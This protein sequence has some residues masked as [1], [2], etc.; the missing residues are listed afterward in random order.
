MSR[1]SN[2]AYTL[3]LP[4]VV[5][6]NVIEASAFNATMDDVA[7][8]LTDSLSVTGKG[9]MANP[10]SAPNGAVSLPAFTFTSDPNSG[11][12]SIGADNVGVT[13][14]GVKVLEFQTGKTVSPLPFETTTL[15]L[16]GGS[17][18]DSSGAI[19]FGNENLSTL[20]T[21]A[22]RATTINGEFTVLNDELVMSYSSSGFHQVMI[23]KNNLATEFTMET[24]LSGAMNMVAAAALELQSG[25]IQ[26]LSL[27]ADQSVTVNNGGLC[28]LNLPTSSGV[29]GSLWNDSGTVKV[30][31]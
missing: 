21:L 27:G 15:T 11:F 9:A 10:I 6:G 18:T 12:Y 26:T 8:A 7:V 19:D 4:A 20:G 25:G 13:L 5:A 30:S 31:V 17:I 23:V 2:G 14:G 24:S 28:F 29:T 3:P 16:A 1:D 22:A